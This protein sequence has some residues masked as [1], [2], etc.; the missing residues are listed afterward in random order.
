MVSPNKPAGIETPPAPTPKG[1]WEPG[2]YKSV[3]EKAAGEGADH[4][5]RAK[6]MRDALARM[7]KK[8]AVR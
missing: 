6:G 2:T 7:Q 5:E 3:L 4:V 1:H 8:D